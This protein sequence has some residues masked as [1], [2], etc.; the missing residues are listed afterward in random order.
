[1]RANL[2]LTLI[3]DDRP[4]LVDTLSRT[5]ATHGGNWEESRMAHL[6]GKFAGLLRV[7]LPRENQPALEAALAELET[8]GLRIV[9]EHAEVRDAGAGLQRLR[10]EVVGNDHEGI[11]RDLSHA[12]ATRDINVEELH[13]SCQDAPMGGGQLFRASVVLGLPAGTSIEALRSTLE[14]LADDLMV[15][16][17]LDPVDAS[18][19]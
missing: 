7:T 3:G 13:T 1:M 11:V 9:V 2:V 10:L 16:V 4:G 18:G 12:L 14:D 15:D 19:S 17:H 5:V 6:A 8:R